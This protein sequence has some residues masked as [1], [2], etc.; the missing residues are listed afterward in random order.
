VTRHQPALLIPG[1]VLL[2]IGIGVGCDN[3]SR[4]A[5]EAAEDARADARIASERARDHSAEV[6]TEARRA[7]ADA[8]DMAAGQI[9]RASERLAAIAEGVDVKT[10][11]M[12]DPS[13]NASRIDV[14]IDERTRVVVLKG[15]VPTLAERDMA[16]LIAAGHA[17]G[18]RIENELTV[19]R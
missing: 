11:L 19:T 8:A 6:A 17:P 10:A 7:A 13:V 2:T 12:T 4:G 14:D 18:Y 16:G 3:T 15:S 5:R 1:I 9:E